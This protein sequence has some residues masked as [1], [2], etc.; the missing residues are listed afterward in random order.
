MVAMACLAAWP[1]FRSRPVML[2]TYL[3]NNLAFAVHY[4]L[5]RHWTAVA[6]NGLMAVQTVVAIG[7]LRVPRLGRAYY[8]LMPVLAFASMATW[9]GLPS[10]LCAAATSLSTLWRMQRSE[11]ILRVLLLASTPF[12]AG[13]DLIVGSLPGLAAD[14]LSMATVNGHRSFRRCGLPKFPSLAGLGV[15]GDQPSS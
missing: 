7:L 11:T 13:H 8:G 3:G 5:L 4:A 1:L 6:M 15:A 14:L 2:L 12:W 10:F 9:N